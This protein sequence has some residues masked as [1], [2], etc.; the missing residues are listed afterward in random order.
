VIV[1][2]LNS[3]RSAIAGHILRL[4]CDKNYGL[5]RRIA[6]DTTSLVAHRPRRPP[7][8][9]LPPRSHLIYHQS[10]VDALAAENCLAS[11]AKQIPLTEVIHSGR[12]SRP[13]GSTVTDSEKIA[14]LVPC[15][16]AA[17]FLPQLRE[18]VLALARPAFR[19]RHLARGAWGRPEGH[20]PISHRAENLAVIEV[21]A[22]FT[23]PKPTLVDRAPSV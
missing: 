22:F 7:A 6:P 19:S 2:A 14:P 8:L 10:S 20:F 4:K 17:R 12:F 21:D 3:L 1:R 13:H 5:A 16:N 18:S 23:R 15:Y 11:L 9:Y